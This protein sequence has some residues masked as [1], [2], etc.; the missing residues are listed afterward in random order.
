M[1]SEDKESLRLLK[2]VVLP[3]RRDFNDEI[4]IKKIIG[5]KRR[6]GL[7]LSHM[8]KI[9]D[10][11]TVEKLPETGSATADIKL[12]IPKSMEAEDI[13]VVGQV[14]AQSSNRSSPQ[15]GPSKFFFVN[16]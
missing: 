12:G 11:R 3:K 4:K 2:E 16:L 5:K 7:P 14:S 15:N 9:S 8:L 6:K 13:L 1:K 10:V